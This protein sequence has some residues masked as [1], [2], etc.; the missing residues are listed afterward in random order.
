MI[1]PETSKKIRE[2]KQKEEEGLEKNENEEQGFW[3]KRFKDNN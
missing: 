3:D 1:F 2:S